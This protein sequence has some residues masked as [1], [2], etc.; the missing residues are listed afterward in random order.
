ML[1]VPRQR[2][3][4]VKPPSPDHESY[5]TLEEAKA[6]ETTKGRRR[7][8][9]ATSA[10]VVVRPSIRPQ[11]G[12]LDTVVPEASHE[13]IEGNKSE[14]VFQVENENVTAE[15]S[16]GGSMRE[17]ESYQLIIDMDL[18][19]MI[20]EQGDEES[21]LSV[22]TKEGVPMLTVQEVEQDL[23][24][25]KEREQ[26][27]DTADGP[28]VIERLLS[29]LQGNRPRPKSAHSVLIPSLSYTRE[30]GTFPEMSSKLRADAPVYV[31]PPAPEVPTY[32]RPIPK[33]SQLETMVP[34]SAPLAR[35]HTHFSLSRHVEDIRN[36]TPQQPSLPSSRTLSASSQQQPPPYSQVPEAPAPTEPYHFRYQKRPL[37]HIPSFSQPASHVPLYQRRQFSRH[38]R[39]YHGHHPSG[40]EGAIM[41]SNNTPTRQGGLAARHQPSLV[42][43]GR[44]VPSMHGVIGQLAPVPGTPSYGGDVH[45][46]P[47]QVEHRDRLAA[48]WRDAPGAYSPSQYSRSAAGGGA[49]TT[50]TNPAGDRNSAPGS[51]SFTPNPAAPAYVP[52]VFRSDV[53]GRTG[54]RPTPPPRR[55]GRSP[56]PR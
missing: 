43:Q 27:H 23:F 35:T 22:E 40:F 30:Q 29:K 32:F 20:D 28:D 56:S 50:T 54:S 37:G 45:M 44:H 42:H 5:P 8:S 14:K 21:V 53:E 11:I 26:K 16:V 25:D 7:R 6:V 55:W 41:A 1:R 33:S 46:A 31:A 38:N 3:R 12:I 15:E 52:I 18:S 51:G 2:P 13:D 10:A 19:T 39:P 17:P 34:F 36:A 47:G 4:I 24:K 9:S 49:T 48:I